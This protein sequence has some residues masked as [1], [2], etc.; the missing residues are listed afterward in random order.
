MKNTTFFI[1][2]VTLVCSNGLSQSFTHSLATPNI[3]LS[4]YS[5]VK[6]DAFSF[7][8]NQAAL[9]GIR[10]K[11]AGFYT[12]RRFMISEISIC[13]ATGILPTSEGNFG[14]E[15]TYSGFSKFAESHLGFAYARSLGSKVDAGIQFNYYAAHIPVYGTLTS[16]YAEG[17]VILHFT[18]KLNGGIHFLNP[19][20]A[21][22]S[23]HS[24]E[25]IPSVY[26]FGWGYDV[27]EAFYIGTEIICEV[28]KPINATGMF[29]Y[30][31][32]RQFF[33]SA[34][35]SSNTGSGFAGLGFLWKEIRMDF[36]VSFHPSLGPSC[37]FLIMSSPAERKNETTH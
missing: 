33:L 29:Q 3:S 10:K 9:C 37:G 5:S 18:P 6:D 17:G 11:M 2:L 21:Q 23:N 15:A 34:G 22:W 13:R 32:S 7:T 16:F 31:F 28:D 35:F 20:G 14:L 8:N 25:K 30:D 26:T 1:L 19:A 27:S 24:S 12:E 4:A 36:S